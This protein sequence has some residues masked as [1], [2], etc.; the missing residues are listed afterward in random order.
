MA[1]EYGFASWRRLKAHVDRSDAAERE[2]V[3]VAARAGDVDTIRRAFAAGF[4]PGATDATGRT[5][6]QIAK[7]GRHEATSSCSCARTCRRGD[8]H[9]T[10]C[11]QA[12][13]AIQEAAI[14]GR[15]E[16]LRRLLDAHPDLIDAPRRIFP[17]ADGAAQGGVGNRH[18]CVRVLL[19]HG[20]DVGIRDFR[21]NAYALH[22]AAADA[23]LA[24]VRMLVEAGSDIV[25]EG[26]DYQVGVLGWATCFR[27]VRE[28]VAEYLLR[29]GANSTC[30]PPSPSAAPTTCGA[31]SPAIRPC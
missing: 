13:S 18:E 1:R 30:G 24:M 4:N 16:E 10:R 8:S 19:E 23:D 31:L 29:A 27:R 2:R 12:I 28:D 25:G 22:L 17:E 21:D 11:R 7:A 14:E 9:P 6:H 15:A 26:D 20:A 3:F 5:I